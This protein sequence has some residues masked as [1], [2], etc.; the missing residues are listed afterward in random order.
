MV[1]TREIVTAVGTL[2]CAVGIG[3]FMQ[4]GDHAQQRYGGTEEVVVNAASFTDVN[5]FEPVA[6]VKSPKASSSSLANG[7]TS[8][9]GIA[10]N[11]INSSIS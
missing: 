7:F 9:R 11:K 2:A 10:R 3:F 6:N 5:P 1:E 4:S 8:L